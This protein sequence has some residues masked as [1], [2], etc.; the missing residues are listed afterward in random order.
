MILEEITISIQETKEIFTVFSPRQIPRPVASVTI[1]DLATELTAQ[2]VPFNP[3]CCTRYSEDDI[4]E[5]QLDMTHP[6]KNYILSILISPIENDRIYKRSGI[7]CSVVYFGLPEYLPAMK[8]AMETVKKSYETA[9]C[10]ENKLNSAV[11]RDI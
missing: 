9:L 5:Y 8:T 7:Q 1:D 6:V 3:K 11:E 4:V 10:Y 2:G